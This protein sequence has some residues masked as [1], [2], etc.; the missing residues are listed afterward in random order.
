M[1]QKFDDSK[2][3]KSKTTIPFV[4]QS[5]PLKYRYFCEACTGRAMYSEE[6]TVFISII[7]RK[8]G[9]TLPYKAENWLLMREGEAII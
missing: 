5:R 3:I 9:A 1:H 8:C 2:S 7:C 4:A 6:P